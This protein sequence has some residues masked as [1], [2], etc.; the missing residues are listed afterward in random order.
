MEQTAIVKA[1]Y[2]MKPLT[3][4]PKQSGSTGTAPKF[5]VLNKLL[6]IMRI[7]AILLLAVT[8]HVSASSYSQKVSIS[9]N[10]LSLKSIFKTI[11]KQ[12]GY[13]FVFD[14]SVI[15]NSKRI[16][17]ELINADLTQVLDVVLH[18]QELTYEIRNNIIGIKGA[19]EQKK[20][21]V[22]EEFPKTATV[23][24]AT[25]RG[26]ITDSLGMPLSGATITVKGT[27][28]STIS[29]AAGKFE[30][31]AN[32]ND[33][34]VITYVGFGT[35]EVKVGNRTDLRIELSRLEKAMETLIVTGVVTRRADSYTGATS[36]IKGEE[37]LRVGNQNILQS[38]KNIDPSFQ[39]LDNNSFGSNPNKMPDI[40]MRGAS[41]F[42]DMK[43]SYQTSP[44]QPLFIIDGFEAPIERVV[45]MDMNR[46]ASVTL[47]KDAAAKALYGSK[48]ANG[49]V[50]IE[51]KRPEKGRMRVSYNANLNIQAPDLTS[52]NLLDAS[53]KLEAERLAGVYT[54][55]VDYAPQ[56]QELNELY[57]NLKGEIARGVNTYWLSK[58]LRTGVGQKHS[59]N[60]DG[61][62]DYIRY[63][64][65]FSYNNVE[66]AMK[67]SNR[68]NM[69]GGF[70]LSYR[71]KNLTFREQLSVII[72]KSNES[73]YGSF[74]D[75]AKLNPYWRPYNE[76]GSVREI[77]G[78]YNIANQQGT[79][80]IYNPLIN[81]TLNTKNR[82]EYTDLTNNFY[83]EWALRPNL[84]LTGRLGVTGKK[85]ENELFYPRD[86]TMFKNEN[87][88]DDEFFKR[89]QFTMTNGK[90]FY[91][92]SDLGV[93]Y[94]KTL[95]KSMIFANGQ[96]SLGERSF[97]STIVEAEGFS[98]DRMDYI[99]HAMQYKA[100]G[101]PGGFENHSRETSVLGS[102]NYSW[103]NRFL[104]DLTYRANGSSLFGSDNKWGQFWSVGLGW[105][106]HN[107]K[108]MQQFNSIDQLRVRGSVGVTG[109]QNFTAYQAVST[110][111]YYTDEV[112]DN[113]IGAYLMG[114]EN[115]ELKWQKTNDQNIGIDLGL[116]KR[117]DLTFDYYIKTTDNLL[118]P[119]AVPPSL[120]F[121]TYTENLGKTENKGMEAK[122]NVKV[123]SKPNDDFFLNVF[124]TGMHNTNK[125]KH[126][127][128]ALESLNNERDDS[129]GSEFDHETKKDATKPSVRYKEGQSMDAIWAVRS[130]GIDPSTGREVYLDRNGVKTYT[131]D[132]KDQVVCGD[133]RPK[134]T[135]TY[136]VNF[137]Y[138]GFMVNTS[139]YYRIGGQ[140][141]NQTLVDKVE[142]VD[143][144][145]N[146]DKRVLSGRWTT[147]GQSAEFKRLTYPTYFTRATS[148]FVQDLTELQ[149]TALTVSYDF[150]NHGFVKRNKFEN[151]RA[152]FYMNDLFRS[153][154]VFTE[155]GT[156]YPFARS[157]SLSLQAT[158]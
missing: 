34:L 75:Y 43:N 105:N 135:G 103:D 12:T 111:K 107:E 77:L 146:V 118:T 32:P 69:T 33:V 59:L 6:L 21:V 123:I 8:L 158:F 2:R 19:S 137:G 15:E 148:R 68:N 40:Q 86:H 110:Y 91:L 85:S 99:T 60:F 136:G 126:I 54:S 81:A 74:S 36:T 57:N 139:F 65:N 149:M 114:L 119:I 49:V 83:I 20:Q 108:F 17:L 80:L 95:G 93:N 72:N 117:V 140:M 156:E 112:Y 25:I 50:V 121:S 58:P 127:S 79:H 51:T 61:G 113:I 142:D 90:D 138:K 125:I 56:Q 29:D 10:N 151:V 131:W 84:K 76:D 100:N 5:S 109:S 128:N 63:N 39:V 143:I 82:S 16:N 141:Y 104:T 71:Y 87:M 96:W 26:V 53:G 66:G 94:S 22:T 147:P 28:T 47:L 35:R 30:I 132:P 23:V 133:A 153:A 101:K 120:G 145:Y 27:K 11:E 129:K 102:V 37:L 150:K 134:F 41:S 122:I 98:N 42:S 13:S 55:V 157:F 154:T 64:A 106:L 124:A 152:S 115:P 89:G 24:F 4:L 31:N 130:L 73:P 88:T 116:F 3:D 62:D 38:L 7:T 9:G 44:N 67:G 78:E 48:G 92:N 45:D 46:V 155:R 144:Q 14:K 52:Y 1:S 97:Q 70:M 18:K